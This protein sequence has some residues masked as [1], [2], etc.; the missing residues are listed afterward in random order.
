MEK[1]DGLQSLG[2]HRVRHDRGNLARTYALGL[3]IIAEDGILSPQD[4]NKAW[5][6]TLAVFIQRCME[7]LASGKRQ[8][9]K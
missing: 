8:E 5:M 3:C 7:L 2:S 6:P 1:P 4:Q 9:N